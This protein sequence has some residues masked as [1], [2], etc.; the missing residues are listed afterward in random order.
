MKKFLFFLLALSLTLILAACAAPI[1]APAAS[2]STTTESTT[3]ES[4]TSEAAPAEVTVREDGLPAYTGE[5]VELRFTWWGD[6]NRAA[7]TQAVID[8]F[9]AAYPE[10]TISGEPR[11]SDQYWTNL[12]TQLAG[13]N[14]PDIMQ[15]GGNYPDYANRGFLEPLNGYVGNAL[16]ISTPEEFDQSVLT[17]GSMDGNLYGVSLGTNAL[18]M[19]YNKSMLEAAGA[20]LPSDNMTWDELIAYGNSIKDLLPEGVFPFVDNSVSQANFIS[21]YMNQRG[22]GIWDGESTH[23]TAEGIQSWIDLWE[24]MREQGLIPDIETAASYAETGTDSSS[25]VAGKAA[26]GLVWSNLVNSYQG[27]MTDELGITQLPTGENPALAIQVSQYL[28]MNAASE[29]KDAVALFINF[30]VNNA[31]AGSNLGTNRGI[32]SSP[33][34]RAAIAGDATPVDAM[35]YAYLN[36]AAEQARTIPQGP[37]LPNDQEFVDTLKQIGQSVSFGQITREEGAQQI[38]DLINRLM[39]K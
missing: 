12:D 16:Q 6:E 31:E 35:L 18:T 11:P 4:T 36:T 17:T 24:G 38:F 30:F 39:V 34:V 28:A 23:A 32:P 10:I 5:P 22:E 29:H 14:A 7:R 20:P 33:V 37:N 25:L 21:Y 9:T 19:I 2:E 3:T 15:F 26:M 27:A 1:Q 8:L 13:S